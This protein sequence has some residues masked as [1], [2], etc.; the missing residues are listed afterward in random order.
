M[1][2]DLRYYFFFLYHIKM[3]IKILFK[4]VYFILFCMWN[5]YNILVYWTN[6]YSWKF[7]VSDHIYG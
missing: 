1:S 6:M 4:I 7:I 3:N 5:N 2:S